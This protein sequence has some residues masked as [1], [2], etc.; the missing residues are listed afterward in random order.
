MKAIIFDL[1]GVLINSAPDMASSINKTLEHF[2]FSTISDNLIPNFI[3]N[4][5]R[6]LLVRSIATSLGYENASQI[7]EVVSSDNKRMEVKNLPNDFSIN[8][9]KIEEMLAWYIAYY[10]EHS[11]ENTNLYPNVKEILDF[12]KNKKIRLSVVSNKPAILS[13]KILTLFQIDSYF[14]CII[15]PEDTGKTKPAPD[16]LVLAVRLM[17]KNLDEKDFLENNSNEIP[18]KEVLMVG[19]SYYDIQAGKNLGCLTCGIIGGYGK[20]SKSS[21]EEI[22]PDFY[23]DYVGDLKSIL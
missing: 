18:L 8:S 7:T 23:L 4:G 20:I 15:G 2:D 3:G 11:I 9:E 10:K 22:C 1:D 17:S 5:A 19:D 14:D 6:V 12:C 16:G 21:P 13:K